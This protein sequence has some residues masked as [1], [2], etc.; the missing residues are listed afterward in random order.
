MMTDNDTF[1]DISVFHYFILE[2]DL[3]HVA[4]CYETTR[5]PALIGILI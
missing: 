1:N 3:E 2:L 4:F 5:R